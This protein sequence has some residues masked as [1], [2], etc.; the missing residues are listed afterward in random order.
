MRVEMPRKRKRCCDG[1]G[2]AALLSD[3]RVFATSKDG[4]VIH[5][6][7][8]WRCRAKAGWRARDGEH[9]DVDL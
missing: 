2:W 6:M 4:Q 1:C 5:R 8:C 3:L 7:E 9:V